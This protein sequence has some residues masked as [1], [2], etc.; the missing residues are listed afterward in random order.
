M[1]KTR[2]EGPVE[3]WW[4]DVGSLKV[5]QL[6]ERKV[7]L[8]FMPSEKAIAEGLLAASAAAGRRCE[9]EEGKRRPEDETGRSE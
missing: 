6:G 2:G 9:P 8:R 7:S 3:F 4:P 1:A 5:V